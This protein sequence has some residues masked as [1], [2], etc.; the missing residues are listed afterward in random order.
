MRAGEIAVPDVLPGPFGDHLALLMQEL[1]LPAGFGPEAEAEAQHLDAAAPMFTD[2]ADLTQL[3]FVTI[4][5]ASS[6]DLDQ[7]VHI[8]RTPAGYRVNYAIADVGA[9]VRPGGPMDVEAHKRGQTFYGPNQRIGLHPSALSESAAS[10]LADGTP[11]PAMVWQLDLDTRGELRQTWLTR[12]MIRSRA[13]LSYEQVQADLD[14]GTASD[15]LRLL[16]EVGRLRQ[17][18]EQDRGGVSMPRPDQE[19]SATDGRLTLSFRRPLPVEEWNAQ[20]SLLTGMAAAELMLDAQIGVLRTMPPAK[21]EDL[22]RLRRVADALGIDWPDSV[23]YPGFVRSLHAGEPA[24]LAMMVSCTRLF[25]GAGYVAFVGALPS[26]DLAHAAL[27][28]HYAHTT[29][30]LRRLVDRYVLEVCHSIANGLPVPEWA[31]A[32]LPGLPEEMRSSDQRAKRFERGAIDLVEVALLAGR[33]GETFEGT[34]LSLQGDGTGTVA[35]ADPAVE[36]LVTGVAEDG[37]GKRAQ[38]RLAKADWETRHV[39]FEVVG[40]V[41][42]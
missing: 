31:Q 6:T 2:H 10:L 27:A 4:D 36:A 8:E 29:A 32:G 18:L 41:D 25:R 28:T 9:W 21:P 34:I 39:A 16:A 12:A 42:R 15:P 23:S 7:A 37:L 14:R 1:G 13:K 38:V 5:P 3:P 24:H 17:Q 40:R 22:A 33:V 20:I 30:P 26:G 35:I 19:V 11:R